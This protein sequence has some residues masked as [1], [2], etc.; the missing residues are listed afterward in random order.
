MICCCWHISCWAWRKCVLKLGHVLLAGDFWFHFLQSSKYTPLLYMGVN[1]LFQDL[2]IGVWLGTISCEFLCLFNLFNQGFKW[3]V[4]VPVFFKC[5]VV[6]DEILR[7]DDA[8]CLKKIGKD[9]TDWEIIISAVGLL[10]YSYISSTLWRSC[11]QRAVWTL[12]HSVKRNLHSWCC[13]VISHIWATIALH[14]TLGW[15]P[16][17]TGLVQ[18]LA[19]G[20]V[21]GITWLYCWMVRTNPA[22]CST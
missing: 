21:G 12:Q 16:G 2:G 8:I 5:F 22:V 11:L 13:W 15:A 19:N 3:D 1:A 9:G 20:L 6:V 18:E 10:E 14:G 7:C 4:Q 17:L